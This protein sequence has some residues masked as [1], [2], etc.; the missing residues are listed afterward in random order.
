M[1][2]QL[3]C[4][5]SFLEFVISAPCY[6]AGETRQLVGAF[7]SQTKRCERAPTSLAVQHGMFAAITFL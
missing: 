7:Y 6:M 4:R 2:L 1:R 3:L 5:L